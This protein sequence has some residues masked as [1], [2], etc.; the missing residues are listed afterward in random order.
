MNLKEYLSELGKVGRKVMAQRCGTSPQYLYQLSLGNRTA[1][2]RLA[3]E[4]EK[5][6]GGVITCESLCPDVDWEYLR[7]NGTTAA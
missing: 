6:S 5:A 4:I 1:S 3:I 7:K 2:P